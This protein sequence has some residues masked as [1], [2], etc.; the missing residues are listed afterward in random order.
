MRCSANESTPD[1]DNRRRAARPWLVADPWPERGG[2][3]VNK[4]IDP[5]EEVLQKLAAKQA[6]REEH[7]RWAWHNCKQIL[8]A[9]MM[10]AKLTELQPLDLL[11]LASMFK[12]TCS[13]IA[14]RMADKPHTV[15]DAYNEIE[16]F[17]K[18]IEEA[19][20]K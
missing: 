7:F 1:C 4:P 10:V 20:G 18:E 13:R 17:V 2:A 5:E 16:G 11:L 3:L 15:E 19:I 9:A 6:H 12:Y 14:V 8:N